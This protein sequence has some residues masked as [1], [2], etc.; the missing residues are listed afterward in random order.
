MQFTCPHCFKSYRGKP[1]HAGRKIR[2]K[3]CEEPFVVEPDDEDF[4]DEF[5]EAA[6]AP[7]RKKSRTRSAQSG[8]PPRAGSKSKPKKKPRKTRDPDLGDDD[9][10]ED[11]E[12]ATPWQMIGGGLFLMALGIGL[13]FFFGNLEENGGAVRMPAILLG[14]YKLVGK[15]G[16]LL[17]CGGLGALCLV[18]GIVDMTKGK[19]D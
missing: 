18:M 11:D 17:I 16:L 14:M 12:E 2:C 6:P 15:M 5:E 13:Y 10:S 8:P 4:D 3:E 19:D 7:R 9:G 1:A